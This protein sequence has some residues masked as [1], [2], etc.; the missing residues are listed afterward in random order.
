MWETFLEDLRVSLEF[1]GIPA[2]IDDYMVIVETDRAVVAVHPDRGNVICIMAF[3]SAG[4]DVRK[5]ISRRIWDGDYLSWESLRRGKIFLDNP[6]QAVTKT[7]LAITEM[8]A[9]I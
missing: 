9:L 3:E 1:H 8:L 6:L 7:R 5:E 4:A 2:R